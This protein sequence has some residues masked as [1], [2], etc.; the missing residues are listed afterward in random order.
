MDANLMS[1]ATP[2]SKIPITGMYAEVQSRTRQ[3]RQEQERSVQQVAQVASS[4]KDELEN[5]VARNERSN[6]QESSGL[7]TLARQQETQQEQKFMSKIDIF[8]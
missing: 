8:A 1:S 5:A 3:T 4:Q 7:Y 6:G 2:L